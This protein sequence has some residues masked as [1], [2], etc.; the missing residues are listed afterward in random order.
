MFEAVGSSWFAQ[1]TLSFQV[2]IEKYGHIKTKKIR[3]QLPSEG[4]SPNDIL[5]MKSVSRRAWYLDDMFSMC[6]WRLGCSSL[7]GTIPVVGVLTNLYLSVSL[8]Q[9]SCQVDGGLPQVEWMRMLLNI[10]IDFFLG[11]APILGALSGL[12][13]K[14]NTR[15]ALLLEKVLT[16][17]AREHIEKGKYVSQSKEIEN[18]PKAVAS[19]VQTTA[20]ADNTSGEAEPPE[21]ATSKE[22]VFADELVV[23]PPKTPENDNHGEPKS[24]IS[25]IRPAG[26]ASSEVQVKSVDFSLPVDKTVDTLATTANHAEP[27]LK[28]RS[29]SNGSKHLKRQQSKTSSKSSRAKQRNSGK[30]SKSAS[31]ASQNSP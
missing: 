10:V 27:E 4:L 5:I 15:N 31:T 14:A 28:V 12:I 16:K 24:I 7:I 11:F 19:G 3:K 1:L 21:G 18:T 22:P 23:T 20:N 25:Q 29:P 9:L 30:H 8:I 6:G 2:E 26:T 17:R 13:Y